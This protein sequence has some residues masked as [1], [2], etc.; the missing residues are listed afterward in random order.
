MMEGSQ[1]G[2]RAYWKVQMVVQ[3]DHWVQQ[4]AM[5]WEKFINNRKS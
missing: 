1:Y 4:Q 3:T 5:M 2:F